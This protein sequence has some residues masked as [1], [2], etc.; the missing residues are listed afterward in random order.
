[1]EILARGPR[2]AEC[3]P[4]LDTADEVLVPAIVLYEVFKRLRRDASEQVATL[5]AARLQ[6]Y[7]VV[8]LDDRLALEAAD[9][10]LEHRL[11]MADAIIYATAQAYGAKVIT[12][13]AHFEGLPGVEY[14]GSR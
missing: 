5:G 6:A 10:S 7:G 8:P 3:R 12:G 4:Y 1:M 2:E 13:D 9:L 14:L 11:P